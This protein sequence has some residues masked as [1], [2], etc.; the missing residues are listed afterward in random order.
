MFYQDSLWLLYKSFI[1]PHLDYGDV[2]FDQAFNESFHKRIES[3]QYS[4]ALVTTV[5]ISGSS[6]EKNYQELGIES[7]R[8]RRWFRKLALFIKLI[9]Q[10][11][12]LI[13]MV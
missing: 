6:R 2:V 9:E 12:P 5:A 7:L 1:R 3:L 10:N 4:A 11:T 13:S 8:A